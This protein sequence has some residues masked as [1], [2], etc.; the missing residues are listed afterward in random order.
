[1]VRIV[2][3]FAL[4]SVVSIDVHGFWS[5]QGSLYLED[6]RFL[7]FLTSF[8]PIWPFCV[9][10]GFVNIYKKILLKQVMLVILVES[11]RK[12]PFSIATTPRCRG[13]WY[14]IPWFA[15][16]YPWS[17]LYNAECWAR[18]H[19]VPFFASLEWL[20]LGLNPGLPEHWR[21]LY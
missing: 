6:W 16:L 4:A 20:D 1:M 21:T 10:Q 2:A 18:R 7:I 9:K 11:D 13:G 14:S 8:S 5:Y 3:S 15:T 12:A 19:Q 17:L